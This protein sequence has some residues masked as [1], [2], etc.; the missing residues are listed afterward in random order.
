MNDPQIR[1]LL[2]ED[3]PGDARLIRALLAEADASGFHLEHAEQLAAGL[4]RLALGG[5]DVVLLDLY[6]PDSRG[7]DTFTQL[8]AH[9]PD[10]PIV[11]LTGLDDEA[12]GRIA[13]REGAQD[14]LLKGQAP[15]AALA[16]AVR[17]AI[18]RQRL[19]V[20]LRTR[21]LVDPLTNLYNRRAFFALA[22]RQ[23]RIADRTQRSLLL[24]FLDAD[25]FKQ[26]NDSFGHLAGDEAL[27]EIADVLRDTFRHSDILARM[28]GDE[29][30]ILAIEARD[31][32]AEAVVARLRLNLMNRLFET[33]RPYRLSLSIGLARYEPAQ[34]CTVDELLAQAD[35]RMYGEKQLKQLPGPR[36][37][38]SRASRKGSHG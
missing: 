12:L 25:N 22:E 24:L 36:V 6:L 2:I 8:H 10:V 26:I 4:E 7:L 13:A 31:E 1:I 20:E 34:P 28:G 23:L 11:I 33:H 38:A 21:S 37:R 14:Y 30:A 18:E 19:V 15:S 32:G 3:N 17:Y 29:F 9:A 5:I 16:R 35:A 27:Q